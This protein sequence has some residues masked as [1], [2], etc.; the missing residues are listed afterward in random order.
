MTFTLGKTSIFRFMSGQLRAKRYTTTL[1]P[2]P[3][4]TKTHA[5][6]CEYMQV[7]KIAHIH[8]FRTKKGN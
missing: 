1:P 7:F 4:S 3:S 6:K 2:T 5:I 8:G